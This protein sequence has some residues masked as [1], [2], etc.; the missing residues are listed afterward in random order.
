MNTKVL[1]IKDKINLINDL[2]GELRKDLINYFT[3]RLKIMWKGVM[4]LR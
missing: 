2:K 4:K 3:T 1:T